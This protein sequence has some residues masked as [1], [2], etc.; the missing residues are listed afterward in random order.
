M[1]KVLNKSNVSHT[2]NMKRTRKDKD[3]AITRFDPSETEFLVLQQEPLLMLAVLEVRGVD[4][5]H[6]VVP[7]AEDPLEV[8]RHALHLDVP[9]Q[10]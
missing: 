10:A 3:P 5:R 1:L 9:P 2:T 8:Q 4:A 7:L 6:V